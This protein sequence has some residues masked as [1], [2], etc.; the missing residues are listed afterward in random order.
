MVYLFLFQQFPAGI[1]FHG[2]CNLWNYSP[3][4]W[5]WHGLFQ[6]EFLHLGLTNFAF[7]WFANH[8]S[9]NIFSFLCFYFLTNK[10]RQKGGNTLF[11][12]EG[13]VECDDYLRCSFFF[14]WSI[15][16]PLILTRI[17]I[18]FSVLE[19]WSLNLVELKTTLLFKDKYKLLNT[20]RLKNFSSIKSLFYKY[21]S[22]TVLNFHYF[23]I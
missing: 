15:R 18:R 1:S 16:L 10:E 17:G 23:S 20:D 13:N 2:R 3:A 22:S 5:W 4:K 9:Q 19:K 12:N 11:F 7:Y 21:V 6:L 14:T 8:A